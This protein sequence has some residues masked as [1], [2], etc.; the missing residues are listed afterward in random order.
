MI[1][2]PRSSCFYS[3]HAEFERSV[4]LSG[5]YTE[6]QDK[7]GPTEVRFQLKITAIVKNGAEFGNLVDSTQKEQRFS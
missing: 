4:G 6:G 5:A 3:T 1:L 2:E 7:H